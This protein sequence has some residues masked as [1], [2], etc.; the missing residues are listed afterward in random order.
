MNR[1]PKQFGMFVHWGPY[2]IYGWHEQIRMRKGISRS[3]YA[4]TAAG[5][6]PKRYDPEAWVLLAKE[7]GM[8]PYMVFSNATLEEMAR[9]K[10]RT[11][12]QFRKISGVGEI[13]TAWYAAAFLK[14][15]KAFLEES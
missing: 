14:V 15:I 13:K 6:D 11:T 4:A 3:E 9:K 5:F 1:M 2:A 8:A 10:P 12:S 7:A